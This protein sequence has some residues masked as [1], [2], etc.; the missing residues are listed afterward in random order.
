MLEYKD[1]LISKEYCRITVTVIFP[2]LCGSAV[3]VTENKFEYK[4]PCTVSENKL[5][6]KKA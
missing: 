4:N 3:T 6:Y 2:G 1:N 5:K